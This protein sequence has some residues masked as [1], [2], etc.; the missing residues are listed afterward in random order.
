MKNIYAYINLLVDNIFWIL[1]VTICMC[2]WVASWLAA[3]DQLLN[4]LCHNVSMI[5]LHMTCNELIRQ[6]R[7]VVLPLENNTVIDEHL[8]MED[9]R[10]TT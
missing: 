8:C 4:H 10:K 7:L 5:G 2:G 3:D 9:N 6:D 1:I